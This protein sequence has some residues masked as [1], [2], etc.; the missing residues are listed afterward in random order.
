[1]KRSDMHE[2][3]QRLLSAYLDGELTQAGQQRVQLHLE[4][5]PACR[6]TLDE[7]RRL[8]QLTAEIPFSDPPDEIMEAFE[9]RLSVQAPRRAGWT[10]LIAALAAWVLYAVYLVLRDP[11]WPSIVEMLAGGL[12]IGA[13]SIFF[14]VLRQRWLERHHDRYTKVRR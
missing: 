11:R 5:C 13:V 1:M 8:Q 14:S 2:E 3:I 4:D 7:M 6:D 12:V 9:Q 10:I